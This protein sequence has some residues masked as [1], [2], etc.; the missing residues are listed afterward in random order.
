M[1][2]QV[3]LILLPRR[4]PATNLRMC[5]MARRRPQRRRAGRGKK[6]AP[7]ARRAA[8]RWPAEQAGTR[9]SRLPGAVSLVR[10]DSPGIPARGGRNRPMRN[11]PGRCV[12]AIRA[13]RYWRRRPDSQAARWSAPIFPDP[14]QRGRNNP[15]RATRGR[16]GSAA[17]TSFQD[18]SRRRIRLQLQTQQFQKHFGIPHGHGQA[19]D[20]LKCAGRSLSPDRNCKRMALAASERAASRAHN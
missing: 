10:G 1:N 7:D 13:S 2:F 11:S 12:S 15:P 16:A 20:L 18:R 3:P 5:A 19:Q 14:G 17:R 6:R 4:L 9:G 8:P